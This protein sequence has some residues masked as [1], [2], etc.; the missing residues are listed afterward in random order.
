LLVKR[1]EGRIDEKNSGGIGVIKK[2]KTK[3][4]GVRGIMKVIC[5]VGEYISVGLGMWWRDTT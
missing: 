4:G 1:K 2:K 5:L 3:L